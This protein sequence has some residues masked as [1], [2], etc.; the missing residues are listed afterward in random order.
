M[1]VQRRVAK[2]QGCAFFDTFQAMGAEGS[3]KRWY[4]SRPR[5]ATGDLRHATP[6]GYDLIGVMYYKAMLKGFSDF[7]R[8]GGG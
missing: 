7:L 2:D 8:N 5:L 6:K 4:R 3:I 1:E